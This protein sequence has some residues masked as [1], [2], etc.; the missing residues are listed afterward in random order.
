M[1]TTAGRIGSDVATTPAPHRPVRH[2]PLPHGTPIDLPGRGTTFVRTLD[3]PP[4]APTL[5]LLHGWTASADLNFFTCYAPLAE[6]YRV[7]ALDHR[8]HGRGIRSRKPFSLE[9]CAD[10][11]I[12]VCD[13]LGIDRVVSIG[14]SMGGPIASLTWRRHPERVDGLVL[15][16]TAPHFSSSR[17][18]RMGFL[19]LGGLATLARLTPSQAHQWLTDQFFLQRR[20]EKWDAWAVEEAGRHD[21][22]MVLEAGRAIGRFDARP[23]L[24]DIDVP[25]SVVVTLRDRVV[26]LHRQV[27]FFE[28]IRE[29]EAFRVDGDHDAVAAKSTRFVPTLLR[30]CHSVQ[31]RLGAPVAR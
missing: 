10:D 5:L 30:A 27:K 9:D 21:W 23:W 16:A 3:G 15:C 29:A 22:R 7:V 18:E 31:E 4:G 24:D 25:T 6:H 20:Q 26:P 13:V 28:G 1:T 12:A 17:Q 8:G 14:Y 19:G 11:A 2:P